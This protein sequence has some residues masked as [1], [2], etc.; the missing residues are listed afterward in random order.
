MFADAFEKLDR[1]ESEA[2]LEQVN[3]LL[4]DGGFNAG[5]RNVIILAHDLPFYP[6]YQLLDLADH[7][8]M[9]ALRKYVLYKKN[10]DVEIIDWTSTPIYR[11]NGK[12][13]IAL[14]ETTVKDYVRLFLKYVRGPNGRFLLAETLEDIRWREE[15]PPAASK[16]LGKLISPLE[17]VEQDNRRFKLK[18][19]IMFRDTLFDATFHV[20]HEGVV[21]I[22]DQEVLV[23]DMPVMDDTL[24]Q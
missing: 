10:E 3:H 4:P 14:N 6:G 18:G 22:D 15:P 13:P 23:D 1:L 24:G 19:Q 11:V 7:D 17:V 2:V 21:K 16:A 12:A 8:S 20:D 9:P 5:S